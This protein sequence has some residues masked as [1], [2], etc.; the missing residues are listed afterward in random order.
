MKIR[1]VNF[2]KSLILLV[3]TAFCCPKT[4]IMYWK[5]MHLLR[6]ILLQ[7]CAQCVLYLLGNMCMVYL[8][9][10]LFEQYQNI[11]HLVTVIIRSYIKVDERLR[12]TGLKITQ[13][14][15]GRGLPVPDALLCRF[16]RNVTF[17]FTLRIFFIFCLVWMSQSSL[18]SVIVINEL[19]PLTRSNFSENSYK[20]ST[21][22]LKNLILV[23][24]VNK[25]TIMHS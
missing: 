16:R 12:T 25:L 11:F 7:D 13:S 9:I 17:R 22:Q 19:L 20:V 6:F 23:S 21:M 2:K 10:H 14:S 3:T 18:Q 5:V 8:L 1:E 24:N 15:S 4:I